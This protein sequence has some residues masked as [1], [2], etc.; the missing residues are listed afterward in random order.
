MRARGSVRFD[1]AKLKDAVRQTY[2]S[3]ATNPNGVFH[4]HRGPDYAV[5]Q[6]GYDPM[7]LAQL[8][9]SAAESFAGV[10]NPFRM[11]R[12]PPG[13]N[14]V[15]IGSGSGMDCLLAGKDVGPTGQVIGI[16][17]TDEM[18]A[19]ARTAAAQMSIPHVRFEKGDMER[20]P[21][22]DASVDVVISNGVIN[23]APDKRTVFAEIY[24]VLRPGGRL[25]FADIVIGTELSEDARNNIDLWAGGIAGA[26]QS[27][28]LVRLV[29][30]AE[31][32]DVALC[33]EF[34][35][36]LGTSKEATAR[37][38]GVMG[39]NVFARK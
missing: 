15:D 39:V 11:G 5:R 29:A 4:F 37:R 12:L 20:L 21:L 35:S 24:R 8:P 34:D 9:R 36:F 3:V 32:R 7:E 16:D 18:L 19:R 27:A 22:V 6:L 31:F 10:G 14:V 2:A 23:L 25:Q 1:V 26:L 13:A 28:E 30:D 17:M 33:E 38:F